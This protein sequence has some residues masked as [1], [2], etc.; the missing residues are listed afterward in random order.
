M[1]AQSQTKYDYYYLDEIV[2]S[3]FFS[4]RTI[5]NEH[6]T[7]KLVGCVC[8]WHVVESKD[9]QQI[10]KRTDR[11]RKE[12]IW[13]IVVLLFI[14]RVTHNNI[15][16]GNWNPFFPGKSLPNPKKFPKW[17]FL[18][19]KFKNENDFNVRCSVGIQI[20][21]ETCGKMQTCRDKCVQWGVDKCVALTEWYREGEG[22]QW[23]QR[24]QLK[25]A[26]WNW[27]KKRNICTAAIQ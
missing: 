17:H 10:R 2:S 16:A 14:A 12:G 19:K 13:R 11:Q 3:S 8:V 25:E 1:R 15:F 22:D 9:A 24:Q 27:Q 4:L 18:R 7:W 5:N 23:Q 26:K 21:N 20:D 6:P